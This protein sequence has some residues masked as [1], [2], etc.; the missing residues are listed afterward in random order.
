MLALICCLAF[1]GC[2]ITMS[3]DELM[4]PP[5]LTEEQEN[6]H[7]AL[8]S[9]T[10]NS[11]VKLKYPRSGDYK[12][13]FV[14]YDID[15]DS[16]NEA[17]VFYSNASATAST[18]ET[19]V[20]VGVFDEI[21][22]KWELAETFGYNCSDI[23][24][25][26]FIHNN[27]GSVSIVIGYITGLSEKVL[28]VYEY[29]NSKLSQ[30]YQ[31]SYTNLYV[32]DCDS[33]GIDELMVFSNNYVSLTSNLQIV[34]P[35]LDFDV[36]ATVEM[37]PDISEISN[38]ITNSVD[39]N[40][41]MYI[42][43]LNVS[44]ML[45]TEII[46]YDGENAVNLTYDESDKKQVQTLRQS[47]IYS[48]DIDSDGEIEIPSASVLP[49]YESKEKDNQETAIQWLSLSGDTLVRRYYSYY[50]LSEGYLFL[51]PER[52]VGLVTVK[53]NTETNETV[54]VKYEGTE[55][56]T[57]K[58]LMRIK[59]V[60]AGTKLEEKYKDYQF[61]SSDTEH[62]FYIKLSNDESEKL[63]LTSTEASF[64]LYAIKK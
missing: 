20:N 19:V 34:N 57:M 49:G 6:I 16:V 40:F 56:S 48:D 51:F 52:W 2:S 12:T 11:A 33:D 14:M 61:V 1:S 3:A 29:S 36:T 64:N 47:G 32:S 41:V 45:I 4:R 8:L 42:D 5:R 60:S 15:S 37:Q 24:L 46:S 10:E 50:N 62:D 13:A 27:D 53:P 25:I 63:V 22:G 21:D 44:N 39:G 17:I 26:D 59:A 58:E 31:S 28:S 54:F 30:V 35:D 38:I 23:D 43:A 9:A 18:A 55:I 7:E